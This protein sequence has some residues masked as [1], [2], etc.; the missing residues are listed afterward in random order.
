VAHD[1][2]KVAAEVGLSIID[3]LF[4]SYARQ[5]RRS[6]PSRKLAVIAREARS[7]AL[8]YLLNPPASS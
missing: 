5:I 6:A 8:A 7:A 4:L 3:G 1:D 2:V